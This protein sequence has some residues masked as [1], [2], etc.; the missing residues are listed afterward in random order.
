MATTLRPFRDYDE[1]DVINLYT[2]SGDLPAS[3]GLLVKVAGN[4]WQSSNEPDEMLGSPGA[5]YANTVSQRYG[6]TS[7][8][9]MAGAGDRPLGMLLFDI[10]ETD[11]NGELLKY[12]PRKAHEMEVAL[13]GQAVPIIQRGMFL[14][15]GT[16]LASEVPVGGSALYA[17]ANGELTTGVA[18]NVQVGVALGAKDASNN[19]VLVKL[20]L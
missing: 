18:S 17:G 12:H 11:E 5:S 15:S 13:S 1:K 3:K 16:Q 9:S 10:K 20:G 14:Y 2:Y 19:H 4:G 6:V 7:K 8:V